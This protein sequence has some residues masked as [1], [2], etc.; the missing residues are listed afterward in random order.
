MNRRDFIAKTAMASTALGV[1]GPTMADNLFQSQIKIGIIG[2]DT[3]HS[4]AFAKYFN[5][6][7]KSGAFRVVAAYPQGSTI[8][9]S[10]VA[11]IPKGTEEVKSYGVEI[12]DSIKKMLK[13]VDCVLLETNDGTVH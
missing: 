5:E 6:T 2:L 3:S 10:S 11:K 1:S 8:I 4:P 9:E 13:Q 7:D 12:V